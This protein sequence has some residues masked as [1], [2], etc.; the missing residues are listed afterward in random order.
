M[1]LTL[2]GLVAGFR[3][4][5]DTVR[6]TG[7]SNGRPRSRLTWGTRVRRRFS[8]LTPRQQEYLIA[9]FKTGSRHFEEDYNNVAQMRWFEEL[10]DWHYIEF[11]P[12]LISYLGDPMNHYAITKAGWSVIE[13]HCRKG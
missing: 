10:K 8:K 13:R 6:S 11:V 7:E 5:W 4:L 12:Q 2:A 1:D 9:R 3:L